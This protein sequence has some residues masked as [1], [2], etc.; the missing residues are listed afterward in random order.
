MEGRM[1]TY[2]GVFGRV[3]MMQHSLAEL[4]HWR[5]EFSTG[6]SAIDIQDRAIFNL[7]GEIDEV[8]RHGAGVAHVRDLAARASR[9][10]EA[11][12]LCEERLLA[13]IGYPHRAQHAAEHRE[14]LEDLAAIRADLDCDDD[15]HAGRAGLQLCNFILGV[16]LGHMVNT[17]SDYCTYIADETSRLSTGSA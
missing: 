8:S 17:D 15:A 7:V 3:P 6:D 4:V 13:E 11:H 12:F 1:K 5:A 10:L 14:V 9:L 2:R 16:V